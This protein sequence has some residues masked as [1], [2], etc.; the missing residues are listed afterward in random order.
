CAGSVEDPRHSAN[1]V[2]PE[3]QDL[4]VGARIHIAAPIGY[5]VVA[6]EPGRALVLHSR[7]D[8][9]TGEPWDPSGPLPAKYLNASWTWYLDP[10]AENETRLIVRFRQ[11]YD[12]SLLNEVLYGFVTKL[13]GFLMERKTLLGLKQRAETV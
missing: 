7:V 10:V 8:T 4:Q 9:R 6:I 3:L 5:A 2:I 11:D 1:R 12:R 13:G